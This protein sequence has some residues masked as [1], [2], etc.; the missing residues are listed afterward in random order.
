MMLSLRAAKGVAVPA[1]F[2]RNAPT[3]SMSCPS[4]GSRSR[5][6]ETASSASKRTLEP[7]DLE[8]RPAMGAP[9]YASPRFPH[10]G[11]HEEHGPDPEALG[12]A[13]NQGIASGS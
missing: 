8:D 11:W 10:T 4:L 2:S 6:C 5:R 7:L 1:S 9:L 13:R 3:R 12:E